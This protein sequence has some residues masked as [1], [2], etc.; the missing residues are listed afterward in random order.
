MT[1]FGCFSYLIRS[2]ILEKELLFRIGV[3]IGHQES[4]QSCTFEV[5]FVSNKANGVL[6]KMSGMD[7][8]Q[9]FYNVI[10]NFS[11]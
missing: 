10:L 6:V 8:V 7:K 9:H 2:L 11:E 3:Q 5:P 1:I 4:I